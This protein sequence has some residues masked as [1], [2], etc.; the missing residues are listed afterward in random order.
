MY[1]IK[2][3]DTVKVL[4]GK[5]RGKKAKVLKVLRDEGKAIVERVNFVKRHM[6][7]GGP[8]GQRGGIIEKEAGVPLDKLQFVCPKCSK[9]SRV[10]T[11]LLEDG[12]RSRYCKKCNELVDG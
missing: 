10:G 1:H 5:E 12:H 9:P 2:K 3:N 6:R 11:K 7:A 4:S 8:A